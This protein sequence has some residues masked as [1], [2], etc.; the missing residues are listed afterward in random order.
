MKKYYYI[1]IIVLATFS[2]V[3]CKKD[4]LDVKNIPA[5]MPI[6][7]MYKT[8]DYAQDVVWRAYSFLPDGFA[9]MDMEAA[10]DDAYHTNVNNRSHTFNYGVWN[11]FNNPDGGAW[12]NCF[13]GIYQANLHLKHR[14]EIDLSYLSNGIVNNDSTNYKKAV[15]NV[16]FMEGECYFLKAFFYFELV[17]RYGGVPIIDQA[18][19]YNNPD[20][21]KS[22]PRNSVND[23]FKYIVSLCDKA[24]VIIPD[25]V[26]TSLTWYESGRATYGAIKALKARALLYAASPLFKEAGSAFTWEDAAA[27]ANDVIKMNVYS[28]PTANTSYTDIFGATNAATTEAIFFRRFGDQNGFEFNNFPIMFEKSNGNSI[29]PSQNFVDE[30]EVKSG[31]TAVPF[32]WSNPTHAANP[33]SNRDPRLAATVVYNG[34]SFS[35]NTIQTYVGGNSGQPKLNATKTGYYLSKYVNPSVSLTNNTKTKHQWLYFR[36]GGLL[37][38]YAEAMF[39][40]YGANSDPKGYGMTALQALNKVRTRAGVAMPALT[41][42]SQEAIMHERR[43]ELGFEGHR[44]WDVR[45]WK[46]AATYFKAPLNRMEITFDGS[47]FTYAVKKLE[48]RVYEE[49]MNWYPIPQNEIVKTG[50]A[51]NTGW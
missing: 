35:S 34:A 42:L 17:K 40:A 28:L 51:Q 33:Y 8:Y 31:S 38:D 39:N 32:D 9:S 21:W 5:D 12:S 14:G 45:R 18:V 4:F 13:D 26:R 6:D 1:I 29:T 30:F 2:F 47:K 50:W 48:D 46:K 43:V 25:S 3:S 10:T 49:K 37:L 27:A 19:D 16:K 41:N 20:T 22:L 11:Q 7:M 23:C 44:L 24:A 15:L 36:Y